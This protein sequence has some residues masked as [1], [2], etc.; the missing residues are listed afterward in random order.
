[1]PV[2]AARGC[3]QGL[4]GI[5]FRHAGLL[6]E[7]IMADFYEGNARVSEAWTSLVVDVRLSPAITAAASIRFCRCHLLP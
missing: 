2:T 7:R 5:A 4:S 3:A 6:D 1:M